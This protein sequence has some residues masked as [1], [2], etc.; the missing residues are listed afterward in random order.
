MEAKQK[1]GYVFDIKENL[2]TVFIKKD[3]EIVGSFR[4][5][6]LEN[7]GIIKEE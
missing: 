7:L 1:D 2:H 3:G 6:A 4:P 5:K